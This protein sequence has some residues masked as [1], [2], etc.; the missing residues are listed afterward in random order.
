MSRKRVRGPEPEDKSTAR[1]WCITLFIPDDATPYVVEK[2]P[3][4]DLEKQ[5][6]G[7]PQGATNVRYAIWQ[8]EICP[9]TG[10]VHWQ[11]YIEFASPQRPTALKTAIGVRRGDQRQRP[12]R[13][14]EIHWERRRGTR[15][16]ARDY[17]R[18]QES[19]DPRDGSGPFEW[20]TLCNINCIWDP[21]AYCKRADD[22]AFV[23]GCHIELV[24]RGEAQMRLF[25]A[26]DP[27]DS[28]DMLMTQYYV[29]L[30]KL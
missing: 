14:G 30:T 8:R 21:C 12:L 6:E 25:W 20:G 4:E 5:F 2:E 29:P 11:G 27:C 17:C 7:T 13:S 15:E 23:H 18:K 1:A 16:Q 26:P 24:A 28:S 10:R 9:D 3:E 22:A 19:R